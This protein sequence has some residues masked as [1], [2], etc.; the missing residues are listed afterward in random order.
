M[1]PLRPD[2]ALLHAPLGDARGNLHLDQPYVLDERFAAASAMVVATVDRLVLHRGGR[3]RGRDDPGALRAPR[4]WRR[5]SAPIR[6]RATRATPTTAPH[7]AEYV[8]AA[9]QRAT[10]AGVPRPLRARGEDAYRAAVDPERLTAGR[11]RSRTGRSCSGERPRAVV[12]ER[13]CSAM[14]PRT[15]CGDRRVVRG[16]SGPHHPRP[17]GRLPRLRQPVRAGRHARRPAHPRARTPCSSRAR[18][19]R[20]TPTRSFIPPTSNDLALHR[21]AVYRMRFEEFFDAACRGDVDRMFLSGG[22]ID[23]HGNTNVTAIGPLAARRRSSSAAEVAAATSRATIGALTAVDHPAPVG[24]RTLVDDLRLRSPTSATGT[25]AG[26]RRPSW[27]TPAAGRSGWSPSSASSTSRRRAGPA[28]ARS[29]PT[30]PSQD[31]E[32]ATGFELRRRPTTCGRPGPPPDRARRACAP[33]TRSASGVWSSVPTSWSG[34]SVPG[35]PPPM[36]GCGRPVLRRAGSRSSA[37]PTGRARSATCSGE[38]GLVPR[39]GRAGPAP[40]QSLRDVDGRDRPRGRRRPGAAAP[41]VAADAAAKGVAAM[42]VLSG[43]FAETGPDGA[44]LQDRTALAAGR[45]ATAARRVV[46]P[47]LLRHPELRPAAQRLDRRRACPAAAAG[48]AWSASPAPTAMAIHDPG[49]DER[50]PVRQGLAPGNTCDVTVDRAARRARRRPG[51]T[52]HALLPAGVAGRRP[53]VRRAGARRSR[54]AS[55]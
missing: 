50:R 46:G 52:A 25:P 44:A 23:G 47:E 39:R 28:A 12:R 41:A 29:S 48:S 22:Q 54:R 30:S 27:A 13:R 37:P 9:A 1:P 34:R 33:S 18:P 26:D 17:G 19:T 32:R 5:R 6:R 35:C 21:G 55:P 2:V 40:A 43:G 53:G 42:V 49:R 38:P 51:A 15:Q 45:E 8:E 36:T 31:V 10:S 11:R 7:L 16:R 14:G 3:R 24:G 20:S 4:S